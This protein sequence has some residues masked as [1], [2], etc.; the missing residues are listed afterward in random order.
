MQ[1]LFNFQ[2]TPVYRIVAKQKYAAFI[3]ATTECSNN[4]KN[5]TINQRL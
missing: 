5:A 2:F 4:Y 3:P 1:V